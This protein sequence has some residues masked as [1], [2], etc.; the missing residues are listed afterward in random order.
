MDF[1]EALPTSEGKEVI[2]VVVDRL[3]KYAHFLALPHP[4]SA[5]S[6]AKL[7]MEQVYKLHGMPTDIVSDRGSVFLSAFLAGIHEE[8]ASPTETLHQLSSSNRR[9]NRSCE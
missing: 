7:F 2:L 6:V 8:D 1:I 5:T 4:Y 3:S 9:P